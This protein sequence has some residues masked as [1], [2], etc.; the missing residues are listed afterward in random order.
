VALDPRGTA[1]Q[2]LQTLQSWNK[3]NP[4]FGSHKFGQS[5]SYKGVNGSSYQQDV[6]DIMRE[7]AGNYGI[8]F[9][10][11]DDGQD[12]FGTKPAPKPPPTPQVPTPP[13][14]EPPEQ[15]P[16]EP[17]IGIPPVA[18]PP[19]PAP[20]AM[21]GLQSAFENLR[22]P[23]PGWADEPAMDWTAGNLGNRTQSMSANALHN[24]VR[25]FGRAY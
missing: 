1:L 6:F 16:V 24:V 18:P 13:G 11:G 10:V 17:P 2:H 20:P 19:T 22:G 12:T 23:A 21:A 25:R 7:E 9:Y 8:D 5:G 4:G 3:T 15:P 14:P